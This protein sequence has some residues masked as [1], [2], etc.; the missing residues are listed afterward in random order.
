M[1]NTCNEV[2]NKYFLLLRRVYS[3][4]KKIQNSF[5]NKNDNSQKKYSIFK[6]LD[7]RKRITVGKLSE[8]RSNRKFIFQYFLGKPK[9]NNHQL[10]FQI[11]WFK[12][13]VYF[14]RGL[15]YTKL[16]FNY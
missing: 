14:S 11:A 8:I 15:I 12:F 4:R 9:K 7:S 6:L 5:S 1:T 2:P 13:L 10:N 3:I 16:T